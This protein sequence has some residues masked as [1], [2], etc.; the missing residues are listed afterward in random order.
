MHPGSNW[1]SIFNIKSLY[2]KKIQKLHKMHWFVV[3]GCFG[4]AFFLCVCC[5]VFLVSVFCLVGFFFVLGWVFFDC[6][7]LIGAGGGE[8]TSAWERTWRFSS[9]LLCVWVRRIK[10]PMWLL[11]HIQTRNIYH[12]KMCGIMNSSIFSPFYI[13]VETVVDYHIILCS[14]TLQSSAV[15]CFLKTENLDLTAYSTEVTWNEL[16]PGNSVTT[17]S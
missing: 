11:I 8:L 16:L 3:W 1:N 10:T 4:G 7:L 17:Q 14:S 13:S 2:Q 15:N 9:I 5:G 12:L 6:L